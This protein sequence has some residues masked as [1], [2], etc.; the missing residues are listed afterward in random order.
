MIKNIH[1]HSDPD[2]TISAEEAQLEMD[3]FEDMQNTFG[4]TFSNGEDD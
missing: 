4:Q 1:H 3:A 2:D